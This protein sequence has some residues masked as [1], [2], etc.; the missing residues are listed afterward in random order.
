MAVIT[1]AEAR[2]QSELAYIRGTY[3]IALTNSSTGYNSS[4]TYATIQADEVT[5]GNGGYQRLSFTY[6]SDDL[7]AYTVGQPFSL[8][9]ANFVHDGSSTNM[10]F[11]H[12]VLLREVS[13]VYSVVAFQDLG[14]TFTLESGNYIRIDIDLTHGI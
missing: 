1:A 7:E 14:Q 4:T 12:V 10:V 2:A 11:N 6:V 13:S 3:Y 9:V 5:A 8:K